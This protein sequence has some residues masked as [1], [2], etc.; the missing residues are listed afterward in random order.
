MTQIARIYGGSFYEL[1][2]EEGLTELLLEQMQEV[3]GLFLQYPDYLKLLSQPSV[4]KAERRKL[5]EQTFGNEVEKYLLNFLKLL[6]DR[7]FLGEFEG[8]CREFEQRYNKAHNIAAAKVT[9]AVAL[10]EEQKNALKKALEERSGKRVQLVC[11][12]DP[13]VLA[14]VKVEMDGKMLDG[15]V[16]RNL[17]DFSKKINELIV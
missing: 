11:Q 15:T 9:S 14:G 12:V 13:L 16:K 6:C 1:A 17:A 3:N 2:A 10:R 5:L 8:C 4:S 7:G